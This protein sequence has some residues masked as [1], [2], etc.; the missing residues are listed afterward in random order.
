MNYQNIQTKLESYLLLGRQP[1]GIKFNFKDNDCCGIKPRE[2]KTSY[3]NAVRLATTGKRTCMLDQTYACMGGARALGVEPNEPIEVASK[4]RV[5]NGS[6]YN[7][8]IAQKIAENMVALKQKPLSTIIQPLKYFQE[9]PDVIIIIGK[10]YAVMRVVQGYS[11]YYGP[12]NN[13]STAGM[14]AVCQD[15][16][17]RVYQTQELNVSFLCPGTRMLCSWKEDELG[18]GIPFKLFEKTFQGIKDTINPFER[19]KHKEKISKE[20][21]SNNLDESFIVFN[22][23]YDDH[24]YTGGAI[25]YEEGDNK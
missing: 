17:S 22:Q 8:K 20:L 13:I 1:V 11:Y 2:Y 12:I 4:R 9:N 24:S 25:N 23:N 18:I 14:Q 19:N 16:T 3:C 15:L 5:N 21:K 7:Q 10:P 6:Y